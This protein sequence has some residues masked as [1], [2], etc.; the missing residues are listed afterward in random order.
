MGTVISLTDYGNNVTNDMLANQIY[1]KISEALKQGAVDI[2]FTGIATITTYCAKS[3][4]GRLYRKLGGDDF[5]KQIV[6]S[7]ANQDIK[8][9]I[10][11]GLLDFIQES[12]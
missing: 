11:E 10:K 9:I 3:I 7:G 4:F 2:D 6:I 1:D 8:I 12:K 5:Y